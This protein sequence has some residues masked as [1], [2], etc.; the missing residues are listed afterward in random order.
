MEARESQIAQNILGDIG[1][2]TRNEVDDTLR[3]SALYEQLHVV[4]VGEY[5]GGCRFPKRYVTHNCR[6]GRKVSADG[7]EVEGRNRAD[8]AF[9]RTIILAVP[10]AVNA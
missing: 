10:D 8:K 1:A 6:S 3:K 4:V 2:G 9:Q 5:G 7:G